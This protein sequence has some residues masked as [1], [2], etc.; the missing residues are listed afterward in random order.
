MEFKEIR[1]ID[2]EER[3]GQRPEL[4][5]L[6]FDGNVKAIKG[7]HINGLCVDDIVNIGPAYFHI[8]TR[9]LIE[10]ELFKAGL[11]YKWNGAMENNECE[12]QKEALNKYIKMLYEYLTR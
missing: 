6:D 9:S 4:Y 11:Y 3:V 7:K 1:S 8:I 10:A 2:I 5:I 12:T